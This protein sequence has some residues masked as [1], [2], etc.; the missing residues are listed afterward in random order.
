M[1]CRQ[2]WCTAPHLDL[3]NVSWYVNI[4][5]R[6]SVIYLGNLCGYYVVE[7]DVRGDNA[8]ILRSS[9]TCSNVPAHVED[10]QKSSLARPDKNFNIRSSHCFQL[11]FKTSA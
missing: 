8:S 4:S 11:S 3:R 9:M 10:L 5:T 2:Q 6:N 7:D 1:L